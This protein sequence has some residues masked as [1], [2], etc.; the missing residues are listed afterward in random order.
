MLD[1]PS[2][3][4]I[5]ID[6]FEEFDNAY[7]LYVEENERFNKN[8]KKLNSQI[9]EITKPLIITEGKTDWKHLKTALKYFQDEGKYLDLDIEFAEYEDDFQ[10]GD[11]ELLK[12]CEILSKMK[13]E[14]KII[15]VFDRDNQKIIGLHQNDFKYLDRGNN[16]YSFCIPIP[17]NRRKYKKISIEFYY[18]DEEL[19]IPDPETGKRLFFSNEVDA[20][21]HKNNTTNSI[22]KKF[23]A[24]ESPNG[25]DEFLKYVF[26]KDCGQI[27]NSKDDKVAISKTAFSELVEKKRKGFENI[28]FENFCLIF[29]IIKE[30]VKNE[31]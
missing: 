6:Q 1:L 7:N 31:N 28:N 20:L 12:T 29:D 3:S 8:Y 9:K 27:K 19:K 25:E 17:A 14:K 2:G 26:D 23:L 18:S 10:M 11:T 13:H 5:S 22:C 24:L 21:I 4:E 16:V 30:I 15:C